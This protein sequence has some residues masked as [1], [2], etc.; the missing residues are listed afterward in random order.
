[1]SS[2]INVI[3]CETFEFLSDSSCACCD[4]DAD[5]VIKGKTKNT[6]HIRY[7]VCYRCTSRIFSRGQVLEGFN[8][9]D[10]ILAKK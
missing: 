8:S 9:N 5:Y 2:I 3:P 4:R 7:D 6:K 10:F 1:M